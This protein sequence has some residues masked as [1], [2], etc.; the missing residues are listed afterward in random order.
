[1]NKILTKQL[2]SDFVT[3]DSTNSEVVGSAIEIMMNRVFKMLVGFL[4]KKH[5]LI[6]SFLI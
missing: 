4:G 5:I 3:L 2:K 6:S 1:M